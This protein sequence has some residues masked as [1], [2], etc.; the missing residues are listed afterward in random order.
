[1]FK[2]KFYFVMMAVIV[3]LFVVGC[4]ENDSTGPDS[5]YMD[6][7]PAEALELINNNPDLLIIDVSPLWADGHLP[8]ALSFPLGDGSFQ[9]AFPDWD[10]NAKYLIYCHGDAPAISASEMLIDAGF[11][12]V[13]RLEGN[14]SAWV[15]AGYDIE[16]PSYMDI[17]PADALELI[18]NNSNLIVI[19]VSNMWEF[20]HLPGALDYPLGD[21][22]FAAAI[23][24]WNSDA[25]YLVYCHTDAASMSAA[26][27]LFDA[28]F[29]NVYRLEG[30]YGAWVDAG[31]T[32]EV[33]TY[34]DITAMELNQMMMDDPDLIVIDVSPM[35]EQG[36]I[37]GAVNYYVGDGSLDDAIP[38]LDPMANYAVY[39]HTDTA[40]MLGANK[41]IDA[42]FIHVYRL[43]GNYAA[44]VNAGYPV[45]TGP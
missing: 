37:P 14:Y 12:N 10:M 23:S 21:G 35:F 44:W 2:N 1:M 43:E 38:M 39:C 32:I 31:Y 28:G 30:N 26:Q 25:M 4:D 36:H 27:M 41:L 11:P 18:N 3:L 34:M 19:D 9:A 45:E 20:G 33:E 29:S 17:V 15:D 16:L 24:G 8:G 5:Q 7:S 40:S 22:S 6:I 13:Y 42:G